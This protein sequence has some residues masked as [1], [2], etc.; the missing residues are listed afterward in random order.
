MKTLI[1]IIR[2]VHFH[3]RQRFY[4]GCLCL[5]AD[6][7]IVLEKP[8][9]M[10]RRPSLC[11]LVLAAVLIPALQ[12]ATL[13]VEDSGLDTMNLRIEKD[14][15]F[16]FYIQQSTD[17]KNFSP[18]S[19][20]LGTNSTAWTLYYDPETP[21]CYFRARAISI[22]APE[23]TDGDGID[24]IY[25]LNTPGLNPLDPS[26]AGLN[27]GH[28]GMTYLQEYRLRF[29]LGDGKKQ[30]ISPEVSVFNTR[31]VVGLAAQAISPEVSV[32]NT[33]PVVGLA[34][35]AISP[36]VSVFNTR[37]VVGLAAEA[38][39]P[40]VSVFNTR[41]ITGASLEAISNEIS[42]LKTITSP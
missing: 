35:E 4:W 7:D 11:I 30:A 31:P 40:E 29:A 14:P 9:R 10:E 39:S 26:D 42:V 19:M 27:S 8:R 16:Y 3:Q 41:P 25:E 1:P 36:E 12:A 22:F 37:P 23:D 13:S 28:N 21:S 38:I 32:F 20:V 5:G 17:L 24:D 18:F 6:A 34:A 15:A 2:A 33:R